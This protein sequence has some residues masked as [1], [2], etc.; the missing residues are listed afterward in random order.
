MRFK[1][2]ENSQLSFVI[3]DS[4][5]ADDAEDGRRNMSLRGGSDWPEN[6]VAS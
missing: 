2:T 5:M 1:L 4:A 6:H 3:V